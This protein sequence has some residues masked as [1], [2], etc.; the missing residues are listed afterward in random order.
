MGALVRAGDIKKSNRTMHID[1]VTQLSDE[2]QPKCILV[3][4]APGVGK[5]TFA[6]KLCR[7]WMKGKLLQHYKLVVLLRLRDKSV[8]DAR[9]I[10]DL[11]QYHDHHIQQ[12]TVEEIKRTGGKEVLLLFEGYDELPEELRMKNSIFLDIIIGMEL[13]EATVLI[14]SRTWA[15]EFLHRKCKRHISQHIEILGF[16][17]ANIRSYLES[18]TLDDP[19]LL[20]DLKKYISCYPHINSLMYI[21]LNSAIEVE[22]YQNSRKD[23]SLVPK[24]MTE[25]YSSLVRSLLLR[26]LLDH[27]VHGKEKWRVRSFSDL[28]QEVYRQLCELGRITYRGILDDQ[29]VIFFDLPE[30]IETLGLMHCAHELICR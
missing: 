10:S 22:V 19:S 16:T 4:G 14:T 24:T 13:P 17:K 15:S 8:R 7:K 28:P 30:S 26:H 27:P 20:A 1:Q 18:V 11:F 12:A 23:K 3:E 5:S 25:L 21:P 9:N 2:S 6:W 29:Q